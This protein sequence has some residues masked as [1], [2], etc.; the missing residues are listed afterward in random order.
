MAPLWGSCYK[1]YFKIM[2]LGERR[3]EKREKRQGSISPKPLPNRLLK[4]SIPAVI[5][6]SESDAAI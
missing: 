3:G 1:I 2:D 6:R 4:N 5:A